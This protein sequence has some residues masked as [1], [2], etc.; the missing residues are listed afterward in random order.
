MR[1]LKG[2]SS[3]WIS[4]QWPAMKTFSWQDGYRAFSV[5]QSQVNDTIRYITRQREHHEKST[6]E[7]EYRR[8]VTMHDL[9]VDDRYLLG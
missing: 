2:E 4:E 5:G 8:F 6:F 7:E 3:K 1:R 9:P